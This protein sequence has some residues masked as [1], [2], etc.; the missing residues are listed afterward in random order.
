MRVV[1]GSAR[2]RSLS[3][4]LPAGVRPTSD[5]VKE[6]IFDILGSLGGVADLTVLDLFCGSG[7]LGIEALSRG[8]AAVTFVDADRAALDAA[9]ANLA[10]VG[11]DAATAR[12]LRA[13]LPGAPLP[14]CDLVLADPPYDLAGVDELLEAIDAELVV[15][16]SRSE[17]LVSERWVVHRQR[18][19]GTT[20]I[21]VLRT[22]DDGVA[23]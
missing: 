11:L 15:L 21:T 20:L 19:Y 8:A 22:A 10:A 23:S 18:R 4:P 1:S 2:G 14:S 6:S 16:E 3:A 12:F 17:P 7:A 9:A 5:R 13:R